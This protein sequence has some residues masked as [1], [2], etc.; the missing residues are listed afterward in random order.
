MDQWNSRI[1]LS[2]APVTPALA[3]FCRPWASQSQAPPDRSA[4]AV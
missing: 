1:S 3:R 4:T 2:F